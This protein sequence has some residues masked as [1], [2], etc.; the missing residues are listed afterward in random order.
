M[1]ENFDKQ[2][3]CIW[4][5]ELYRCS[6]QAHHCLIQRETDGD[7]PC[8]LIDKHSYHGQMQTHHIFAR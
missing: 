7:T 8:S 1:S 6:F 4:A 3:M 2:K 5:M